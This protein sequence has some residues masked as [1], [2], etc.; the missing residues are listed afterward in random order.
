[1]RGGTFGERSQ[2]VGTHVLHGDPLS[3]LALPDGE[4]LAEQLDSVWAIVV[5]VI[6]VLDRP[7]VLEPVKYR[8]GLFLVDESINVRRRSEADA[9]VRV[10]SET[11]TESSRHAP[12]TLPSTVN[13]V[14]PLCRRD[15]SSGPVRDR[16]PRCA[17]FHLATSDKIRTKSVEQDPICRTRRAV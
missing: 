3:A 13:V 4:E 14:K 2:S 7:P 6:G 17:R 12:H 8:F 9:P 15:H 5:E 1:M 11:Q 16:P 10:A